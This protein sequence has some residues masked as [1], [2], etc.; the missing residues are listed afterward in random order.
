MIAIIEVNI[1]ETILYLSYIGFRTRHY[2]WAC[3][4]VLSTKRALVNS[5]SV[6]F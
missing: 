6:L 5:I 4:R 1:V 3:G 2:T